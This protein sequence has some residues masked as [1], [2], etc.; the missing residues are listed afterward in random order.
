[1]LGKIGLWSYSLYLLHQPLLHVYAHV[2]VWAVPAQYLSGPLNYLLLTATWLAIIPFSFCWY[3]LIEVPGIAWGRRVARR[4]AAPPARAGKSDTLRPEVAAAGSTGFPP[5]T[6]AST[7]RAAKLRFGLVMVGFLVC[8]TGT[9]MISDRFSVRRA[10]KQIH[11]AWALATSPEPAA[12]NGPLAVK[13]AEEACQVTQFRQT[14]MVETLAAAY[15]EAGRF[16]EAIRAAELACKLAAQSGDPAL[17]RKNQELLM[18]FRQGK[19]FHE[20]V[21]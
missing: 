15:A 3:K 20:P 14:P 2:I 19:P 5:P 4:F 18:L 16:D 17:L 11:L 21:P 6:I 1:L 8:V 13:L 10:V 9:L 12:R 7:G